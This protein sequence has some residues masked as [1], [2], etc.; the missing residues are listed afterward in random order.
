MDDF[1]RVRLV[2]TLLDCCGI[3]F[4][5]GSQKRKLDHFLTVFQVNYSS[6]ARD[7]GPITA[8]LQLYVACKRELPMDV[9][10]MLGDTFEVSWPTS[11]AARIAQ[12]PAD[13]DR[14]C[15]QRLLA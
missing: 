12:H 7:S 6:L 9:E 3:C 1:F 15:D 2:C 14:L 10:F 13:L 8:D 5:R 4:D 11:G